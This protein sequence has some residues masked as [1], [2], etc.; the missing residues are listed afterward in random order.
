M[1]GLSSWNQR[2]LLILQLITLNLKTAFVNKEAFYHVKEIFL[3]LR[4]IFHKILIVDSTA[5]NAEV[6][7]VYD[8]N[9]FTSPRTFET[10]TIFDNDTK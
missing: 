5:K 3:F 10:Y 2:N 9:E 6:F 7:V 8:N 1:E 4:L